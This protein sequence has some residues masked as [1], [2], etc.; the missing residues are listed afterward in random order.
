[1]IMRDFLLAGV[2]RQLQ[3]RLGIVGAAGM[4]SKRTEQSRCNQVLEYFTPVDLSTSPRMA[5]RCTEC[6]VTMQFFL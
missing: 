3:Y 4:C 1:M 2:V 5:G 6:S